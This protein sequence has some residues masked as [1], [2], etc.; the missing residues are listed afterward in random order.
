[1][2]AFFGR[3]EVLQITPEQLD[4]ATIGSP[5]EPRWVKAL[6]LGYERTLLD[7][8][9]LSLRIGGSYTRDFIPS[10]FKPQYGSGPGGFKVF[11]RIKFATNDGHVM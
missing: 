9:G 11:L 5:A 6:T 2:N 10:A 1:M 7:Q 4:A 3:A 8:H